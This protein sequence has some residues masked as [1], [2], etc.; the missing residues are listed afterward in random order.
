MIVATI[1]YEGAGDFMMDSDGRLSRVPEQRVSPFA[2]PGVQ[3]V[4]PRLFDNSPKGA[5]S[6][7]ILWDRAIAKGR[8]F[9][10]RLDGT[11]MHIGTAE[12]LTESEAFLAG[13]LPATEMER[14]LRMGT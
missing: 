14:E 12:A 10:I 8:M 3:I 4:H 5:F 11:W 6:T 9:G 2:F 1:G 13:A 7:N